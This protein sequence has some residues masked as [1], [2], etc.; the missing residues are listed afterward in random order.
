MQIIGLGHKARQGKDT[1]GRFIAQEAAKREMHVRVYGFADALRSYCRVAFGMRKKDAPLLQVVGTD[2]FRRVDPSIWCR[3]L[4]DTID[5]QQPDLAI[6]TDVRFP[7]EADIV[8]ANG[9]KLIKVS[10]VYAD[11]GPWVADD[12]PSNHAS[13]TA[14]NH[15]REWDVVFGNVEGRRA[16]LERAAAD[17]FHSGVIR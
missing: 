17:F 7:N 14:L 3:V 2:V 15:Y 11:G 9:G 13:E 10:R 4:M 16:D 12:R 8:K 6:I 1:L 5:E